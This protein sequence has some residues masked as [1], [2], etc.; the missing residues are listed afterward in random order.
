M[1]HPA[2]AALSIPD[3]SLLLCGRCYTATVGSVIWRWLLARWLN[4]LLF[5][6][7]PVSAQG[8]R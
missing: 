8:R 6:M 7:Q 1:A 5:V 2:V 4:G 3:L